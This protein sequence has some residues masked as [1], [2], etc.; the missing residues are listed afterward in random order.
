[1]VTPVARNS[2]GRHMVVCVSHLLRL[3]VSTVAALGG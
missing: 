3:L 1:L 2:C